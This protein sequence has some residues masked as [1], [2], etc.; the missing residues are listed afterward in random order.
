MFQNGQHQIQSLMTPQRRH[1]LYPP[2]LVESSIQLLK[3]LPVLNVSSLDRDYHSG[4]L[5]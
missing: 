2:A 1:V 4:L 5:F 3:P